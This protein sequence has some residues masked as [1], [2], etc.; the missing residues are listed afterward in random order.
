ME[1]VVTAF[2]MPSIACQQA[3]REIAKKIRDARLQS[4]L[5]Q[6]DVAN[7]LNISQ[8]TYS[9][10]E[11]GMLAPDSAQIRVLSGLHGVSI[12]WLLGMPNYFVYAI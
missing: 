4:G 2:A 9:R 3:R 6:V 12:L 8:S 7:A 5:K 11:R 1:R 10:M